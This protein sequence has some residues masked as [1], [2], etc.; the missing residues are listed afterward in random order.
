VKSICF[1]SNNYNKYIEIHS[2]LKKYAIDVHFMRIPLTEIQSNSLIEIA[3]EKS[4]IAFKKISKPIIVEDDGL[5]I[6]ELKGFPGQYSSYSFE[7]IGY[8]G[9]L[10]LL[11]DSKTRTAYF[12]SVFAFYDGEISQSFVGEIKGKIAHI[13]MGKGWGYDPIFIPDGS[14]LTFGQL[15]QE[16]R[17][18]DFSHRAQAL[19]KFAGWYN[20][21]K[22]N[23]IGYSRL[24]L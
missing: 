10:K 11:I 5:F 18:A 3:I 19:G 6:D 9:I 4:K 2:V 23:N 21:K 13:P 8:D 12:R 17:K 7:T 20:Y 24:L 16:N 1:A 22:D 14:E 15:Y